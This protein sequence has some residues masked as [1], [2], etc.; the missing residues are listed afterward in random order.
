MPKTIT[1]YRVFLGSPG[2]LDDE[3]EKFRKA[4][5]KFSLL[6]AA[7]KDVMFHAVGWENT[8]GG[9]GRPQSLI[10]EDLKT[11]DYAVFVFHDRWGSETGN[12]CTS[13]TEEEWTLAEELYKKSEI[14]NIALFFK[15]V[16]PERLA[17]PG[18]QLEKV[19]GSRLITNS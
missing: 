7:R 5:E 10:N 9:A 1:Q 15:D 4:L 6:H 3:R 18:P 17:D 2:G 11:C 19:L 13:G 14:R 16:G 8:I 12:G